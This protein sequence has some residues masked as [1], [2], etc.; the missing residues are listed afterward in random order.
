MFEICVFEKGKIN[1][2]II[3]FENIK[4]MHLEITTKCNASCPMC[5]RNYKGKVR[6]KLKL[7]ELSLNECKDIFDVDFIKQLNRISICGVYGDP[8]NAKEIIEIVDYFYSCNEK[9][10]INLY[11][12]GSKHSELWWKSL[13]KV[14]RNKNGYVIFGIDG[15]GDVNSIHRIN[16]SYIKIIENAKTYINAGGKAK[17]DFIAFKHNENLIDLAEELSKSIGFSSF[18]VKKTSRFL[19]NL[20]EKDHL[21]DS[22][23]LKYGKHPIYDLDGKIIN[24]LELA[25]N[26]MNRNNTENKIFY[27]I[28]K[29]GSMEKYF[30]KT[31]IECQAIKSNGIFISALGEVYPCCSVY[32]QVC[33]GLVYGVKDINELNEY[34]LYK[35]SNLSAFDTSIKDI[36]E[37]SFFK[38]L[39]KSWLFGSVNEGK[40][41]SCS[42]T[43]GFEVDMHKA[44]HAERE[45]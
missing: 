26:K 42:Q 34:M 11:T 28:K 13:A 7:V 32:Q 44:Q 38:Q 35:H 27:L 20:Y 30:D 16:T 9:L 15:I 23:I 41:K 40:P 22:T 36:V 39:Q 21:L 12:N 17:W 3:S 33:Y 5:G 19:K 43:C 4:G 18:Q 37:G 31:K 45:E 8:I 6:D 24:C 10:L 29:Y 14:M 25:Q 2:K 1:M